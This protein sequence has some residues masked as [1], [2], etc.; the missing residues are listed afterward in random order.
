MDAA[1]LFD[2]LLALPPDER[3]EVALRALGTLDEPAQTELDLEEAQ[4]Q[5][6]LRRERLLAEG[7]T[8]L[9][10]WEEVR[11]KLLADAPDQD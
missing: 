6:V 2:E 5:E 8:L 9:V 4:Y 1:R 7:K 11:S 10:P 3:R